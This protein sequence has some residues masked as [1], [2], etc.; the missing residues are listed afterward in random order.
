M[1]TTPVSTFRNSLFAVASLLLLVACNHDANHSKNVAS[2]P[3]T[4]TAQVTSQ[5]EIPAHEAAKAAIDSVQET[6]PKV[7]ISTDKG[8]ITV[9][10]FDSTPEHRDNF[11]KLA[12]EGFYEDLL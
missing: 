5:E 12:K 10:L 9:M 2:T 6:G 4:D 11:L 7:L 1:L 3:Q 8:D